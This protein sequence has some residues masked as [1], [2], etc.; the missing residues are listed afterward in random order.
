MNPKLQKY[1]AERDRNTNRI[2]V[3]QCRNVVLGKKIAEMESLELHSML[4]G[5]NMTFQDLSAYIR[6]QAGQGA[7]PE[8]IQKEDTANEED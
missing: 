6:T 1:I 4:R 8:A 2:V 3:L 5:A 7:T